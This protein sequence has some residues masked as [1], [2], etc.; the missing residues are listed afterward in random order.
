MSTS[1]P[2]LPEVD[3]SAPSLLDDDELQ[4]HYESPVN[5]TNEPAHTNLQLQLPPRPEEQTNVHGSETDAREESTNPQIA[6]LKQMFPDFDDT[7][8]YVYL[9]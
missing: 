8:L 7:V 9:T 4:A 3:R 6:S 2:S 5:E 1:T